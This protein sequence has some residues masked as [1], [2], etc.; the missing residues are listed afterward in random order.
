MSNQ[1]TNNSYWNLSFSSVIKKALDSSYNRG[2]LHG[3]FM[4]TVVTM[5]A[6]RSLK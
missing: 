5:V 3:L 2:F 6:Y 1:D 4:G